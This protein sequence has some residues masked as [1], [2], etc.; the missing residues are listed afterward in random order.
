MNEYLGAFE[1]VVR[2]ESRGELV[3]GDCLDVLGSLPDGGAHL[4]FADPPF[5]LGKD[6]G[7]DGDRRED[8]R[9]WCAAWLRG[10]VRVL[11]EAGSLFVMAMA[12]HLNFLLPLLDTMAHWRSTIVWPNTSLP[13][14]RRF[15]PA[16]QPVLWYTKNPERW[17]YHC[18]ADG[19]PT[20]AALPWGRRP[21]GHTMTDLWA[22]IKFVSGG[23]MASREAILAPGSRRKAHPTQ[24]PEAL[25]RRVILACSDPGD[26]VLDLFAGSGTFAVVA[27]R[28][29]RRWFGCDTNPGYVDLATARLES[30]RRGRE[31][32]AG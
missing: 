26:V 3:C 29:G 8:Y 17:T 19:G 28:L 21:R 27:D 14:R 12:A 16:W 15:T 23:C 22:D 5:N 13:Q 31:Q 10:A 32:W 30:D 2:G 18:D 24:M 6:Y 9:G 4:A 25:A 7:E 20:K 11:D 1:R